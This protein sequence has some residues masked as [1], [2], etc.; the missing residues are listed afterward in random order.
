[1]GQ[2][3]E[4][5]MLLVQHAPCKCTW[6]MAYRAIAPCCPPLPRFVCR[7]LPLA[8]PLVVSVDRCDARRLRPSSS[9]L[10]AAKAAPSHLSITSSRVQAAPAS[11]GTLVALGSRSS[12]CVHCPPW[13]AGAQT[14][15]PCA[16]RNA[17]AEAHYCRR[18][19]GAA[20]L[21]PRVSGSQVSLNISP[22]KLLHACRARRSRC[23]G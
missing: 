10:H 18:H 13:L 8:I 20:T 3:T 16:Q 23:S 14:S 5:L 1:M 12:M 11:R 19:T 4:G 17:R 9:A 7:E 22:G 6:R 2:P 15:P 21:N